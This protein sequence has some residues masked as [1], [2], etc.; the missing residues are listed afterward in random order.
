MNNGLDFNGADR[1]FDLIPDGT[2]CPV[3]MAIRPGGNGDGGWLKA[4]KNTD[5]MMLDCEI[6]VTDGPFAKRKIYQNMVV[7]GGSL[8]EKGE[9]KAGNI[10]R[11][12]LRA[13][14]ES[15]R[16]IKPDD[17]TNEAMTKRRVNGWQDFHGLC[18]LV[19][20]GIE[21]GQNGYNDKN[22][23]KTVI[24]PD[25][26]GYTPAPVVAAPAAMPS[27]S[28][29]AAGTAPAWAASPPPAAAANPAPAWA[30]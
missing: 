10:T 25:M 28:A 18:F 15:A 26:Q 21:K 29:P 3:V 23:I 5:A 20:V 4:S 24:T 2:V 6:I 27:A 12:N 16:N 14:L 11:A 19:K 30:Q 13:I 7:S 9:S 22:R 17:M 1:Q 8:N